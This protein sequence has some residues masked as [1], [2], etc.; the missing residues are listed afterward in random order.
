[1]NGNAKKAF[2]VA[3][4]AIMLVSL[5]AG[6]AAAAT[7]REAHADSAIDQVEQQAE[8]AIQ[9]V[10]EI[11]RVQ[12]SFSYVQG[13]IASIETIRKNL[14]T[15]SK[16]LCGSEAAGASS[17]AVPPE[18]WVIAVKGDVANSYYATIAELTETGAAQL[19]MGCSCI[20]NP[21]DGTASANAEVLGVTMQSIIE[22]AGVSGEANT[23]VFTSADG[24]EIAIPLF[25]VMQHFSLIAYDINGEPVANSMGG[26][27]QLWLGSTAASYFSRDIVEIS[28]ESR[29]TPPPT[30]GTEAAG[31]AYANVPNVSFAEGGELA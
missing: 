18:D 26:S 17:E 27:N 22:R 7:Q 16:Y 31:D 19:T 15:A 6:G 9:N 4:S 12:G 13:E 10:S 2:G 8:I 3:G 28:F 29:E 23:I 24:Y 21:A 20:G 30:P 14:A 5:G 25:Y 1:M 11:D